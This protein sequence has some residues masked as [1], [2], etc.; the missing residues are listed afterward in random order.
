MKKLMENENETMCILSKK[1][2]EEFT[3]YLERN[4]NKPSFNYNIGDTVFVESKV[5]V[6]DF[7]D[8]RLDIGDNLYEFFTCLVKFI[9]PTKVSTV[10]KLSAIHRVT[11]TGRELQNGMKMY[12]VNC[13]AIKGTNKEIFINEDDILIKDN[14]VNGNVISKLRYDLNTDFIKDH[15]I[16]IIVKLLEET[17]EKIRLETAKNAVDELY[18]KILDAVNDHDLY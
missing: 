13:H 11:I 4:K 12:R 8:F 6:C 7:I 15:A 9:T 2:Y 14:C 16:D 1:E 5:N 17:N 10:S 18:R 3:K